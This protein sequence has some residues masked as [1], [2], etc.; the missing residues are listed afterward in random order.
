MKKNKIY[1]PFIA[2]LL[3]LAQGSFAQTNSSPN[4][5]LIIADDVSWDD[6]AAYGNTKIKTPNIDR[7]AN[8]GVKF[9]N[10]FLVTSSC[11]PSRT[12]ILTGRYPHN[13]GAAELHTEL[14]PEQVLLPAELKKAGYYTALAGKWHEGKE[15]AKAYDTLLVNKKENGEGGEEQWLSLLRNSF[16]DKPFFLWLASYDAHRDWSADSTFD[17]VYQNEEVSVPPTLVDDEQTRRD[18]VSYY[19]EITRLDLYVGK[20]W[21]EL[22]DSGQLNNT[23]IIFMADNGRPFPGSKT[24]LTDRGIKTPLLLHWPNGIKGNQSIQA[25]VS[26][27]DISATI[28]DIVN[29]EIPANFQG[30]SFASLFNSDPHTTFRN[31]V[32]AEHNWHDYEAYERSVRTKDFLYIKNIRPQFTNDGPIDANQSP[33]ANSLKLGQKNGSLSKLQAE[34]YLSSRPKEE[35]YV[36]K[37]DSLQVNNQIDNPAFKDEIKN[38]RTVLT[39]WQRETG[40]SEPSLLTPHWY[41]KNTAKPLPKKGQRGEMPGKKNNANLNLNPGPF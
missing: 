22:E 28:L 7:L 24:R 8:S 27:I 34:P 5:I 36:L 9:E 18:L 1:I 39:Q 33:S 30:K 20:I 3:C 38:L 41:D 11:S 15:T 10:A 16:G 35:F 37:D 40:D 31:Y 14:G 2:V 4:I 25:L 26:S 23:I 32:F 19:N 21:K 17:H 12:S 13:T 29:V 6:I